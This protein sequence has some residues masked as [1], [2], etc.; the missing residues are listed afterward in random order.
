MNER[1]KLIENRFTILFY[2][3]QILRENMNLYSEL[4][5]EHEHELVLVH[6]HVL[7]LKQRCLRVSKSKKN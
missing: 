3:I 1:V 7:T 6:E 2:F 5:H 4:E